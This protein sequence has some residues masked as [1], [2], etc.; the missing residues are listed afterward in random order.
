MIEMIRDMH[1][2]SSMPV[3]LIGMDELPGK[4]AKWELVDG[5][6]LEW[7]GAEP[8]DA[9]DVKLLASLYAPGVTLDDAL[10]THIR[11][12]HKG[13]LRWICTD[14]AYVLEH[15]RLQ[16][17]KEMSLDEWGNAP[18]LRGNAPAPREF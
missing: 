15:C 13:Q 4:L 11:D 1:D 10:L 14:I 12:L 2:G 5:R 18:F 9:K 8:G 17:V 16:G 6:I 7:T 3:I